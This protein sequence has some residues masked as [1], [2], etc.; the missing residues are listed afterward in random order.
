MLVHTNNV[1]IEDGL[2]VPT[3]NL[4]EGEH[5]LSEPLDLLKRRRV[6]LKGASESGTWR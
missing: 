6:G 1:D 5:E 3:L 2:V 4:E